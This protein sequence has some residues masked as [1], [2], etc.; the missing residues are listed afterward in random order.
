MTLVV[1]ASVLI[2]INHADLFGPFFR[3]PVR[4]VVPDLVLDELRSFDVALLVSRHGLRVGHLSGR[5]VL[6]LIEFADKYRG[7]GIRDLS[8][9]CLAVELGAGLATNDRH[10]RRAA[11][12]EGVSVCGTLWVLDELVSR[13]MCSG[14]EAASF[15]RVMLDNSSRLPSDECLRRFRAWRARGRTP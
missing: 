1:D 15:L 13:H 2:D 11:Y 10:L 3:L 12:A 8:V 9:L 4:W 5:S 6:T 7:P 14:A